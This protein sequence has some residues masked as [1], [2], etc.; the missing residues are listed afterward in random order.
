MPLKLQEILNL[1]KETPIKS[2]SDYDI[3]IKRLQLNYDMKLVTFGIDRKQNLIIQFPIFVQPYTQQPLILY[4]IETV[5][6]PIVDQNTKA[7]SYMEILVKKPYIALNLETYINIQQQELA[8]CKRIVYEFYCEEH[9]VVRHKSTH[10]CES[11]IYFDLDTDIIK[12][13]CDF[14]FYYN[15]SD[16]TLT[17]LDGGKEI[18]PANWPN[19]KHTICNINNDIPIEI[20]SHPYVL[21]NRNILCN[22]RIEAENNFLLESLA[23]CHDSNTKLIMFFTINNAFTNYLNEFNLTEELDVPLLTNKSMSELTLPVFLNKSTFD[24]MLLSAH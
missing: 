9:F 4:Q 21:V 8:T 22:C 24:K 18:I 12:T 13:N 3:V 5:P 15:K 23:T 19:N 1:V 20:Q 11:S 14:V 17:V 16:I 2:K 6:V 7:D 10:S